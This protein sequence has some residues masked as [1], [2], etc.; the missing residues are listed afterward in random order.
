[1]MQD[2]L[3]NYDRYV[4]ARRNGT[5]LNDIHEEKQDDYFSDMRFDFGAKQTPVHEE[6]DAYEK[7]LINE[8]RR[9]KPSGQKVMRE[10]EYKVFLSGNSSVAV[11]EKAEKNDLSVRKTSKFAQKFR[12]P[13]LTK[14]GK[15]ILAVYIILMVALAS[16]LIVSNTTSTEVAFNQS[17]NASPALEANG[18][19]TEI[20]AMSIDEEDGEESNWFDALCDSLNK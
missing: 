18:D 7:Y 16:I 17:A 2:N 9:T 8:L 10:D 14:T 13:H 15:I 20:R 3:T 12:L 19:P 6:A 11:V 1:M 4:L 5:E